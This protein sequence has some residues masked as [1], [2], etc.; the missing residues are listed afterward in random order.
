MFGIDGT[1]VLVIVLGLFLVLFLLDLLFAGGG[2]TGA[3]M[4]GAMQCGAAIMSSPL[5]WGVLLAIVLIALAAFG[6]GWGV[7]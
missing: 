7:R 4:T 6:F 3:M 2:M 1:T 5:G